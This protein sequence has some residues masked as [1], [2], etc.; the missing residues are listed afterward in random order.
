MHIEIKVDGQSVRLYLYRISLFAFLQKILFLNKFS[1]VLNLR[2][3]FE[4]Q[5]SYDLRWTDSELSFTNFHRGL[6]LSLFYLSKR[7]QG[8]AVTL[9]VSDALQFEYHL[10][11][12]TE[13]A[14]INTF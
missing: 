6:T 13:K 10:L 8:E 7:G 3:C 4:R 1:S 14:L 11:S 5:K 12:N 9:I 2:R